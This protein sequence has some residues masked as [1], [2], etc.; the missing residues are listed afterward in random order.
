VVERVEVDVTR[1]L[2]RA[3]QRLHLRS[4]IEASVRLRIKQRLDAHPVAREQQRA[5]PRVPD[6]QAEHPAQARD[7]RRSPLFIGVDDDLGVRGGPEAMP[8]TL[9]LGA[10]LAKVVDLA[11]EDGPD[12][13]VLVEDRLLSGGEVDNA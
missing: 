12:R 8:V 9:E 13:A 11:V 7:S 10:Q 3:Q 4:E 6:G 1:H 2:G 5:R